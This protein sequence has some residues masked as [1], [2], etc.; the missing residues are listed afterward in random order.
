MQHNHPDIPFERYADDAVCHCR[1]EAQAQACGRRWSSGL[2]RVDWSFIRRRRRLSTVKMTTD[3]GTIHRNAST[4]WGIRFDP[5]GRRIGGASTSSISVQRRVPRPRAIF[6]ANYGAG[7]CIRVVTNPWRI[8]PGCLILYSGGGATTIAGFTSRPSI[9]H[10]NT[11]TGSWS[12]G[13]C[14]STSVCGGTSAE[15]PTGCGVLR[16]VSRTCA[17]IGVSGRQRLDAKSRMS[18]EVH[19]RWC[20][21]RRLACSGGDKTSQGKSQSPVARRAGGRETHL[22]KPLDSLILGMGA[23]VQAVAQANAQVA[24]QVRSPGGRAG[25]REG[26]GSMARRRLAEAADHAG[27]VGATAWGQGHAKQLEK[28]SASRCAIGGSKVGCRTGP[29]GNH[30]KT[31]GGRR[32]P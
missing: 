23:S 14:G 19:V 3:E 11:W 1:T 9:R 26:E 27:G 13:R 32:G 6:G 4:F 24:P 28:P 30:P 7:I 15:R 20:V 12:D 18:C 5:G 16:V 2:P 31:R 21:Q 8:S 29:P 25:N 17:R 10:S 22:L